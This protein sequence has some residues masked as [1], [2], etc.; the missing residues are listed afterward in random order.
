MLECWN[1]IVFSSI[2]NRLLNAA[3]SLIERERNGELVDSKLVI[4]VRESF[5]RNK[6][7]II[8]VRLLAVYFV[9]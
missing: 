2:S 1:R 9:I 4:G 5:G 7:I 8:I 6:Y 3:M